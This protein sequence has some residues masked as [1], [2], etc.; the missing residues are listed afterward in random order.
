MKHND[1]S[2]SKHHKGTGRAYFK[3]ETACRK[4]VNCVTHVWKMSG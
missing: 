3:K 4:M 2:K 1:T